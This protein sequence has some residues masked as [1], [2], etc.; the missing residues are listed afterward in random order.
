MTWKLNV[1]G[2][3]D[4]KPIQ[5]KDCVLRSM[6]KNIL[7]P[8]VKS[9]PTNVKFCIHRL[10]PST[11]HFRILVTMNN[12]YFSCLAKTGRYQHGW[13][14]SYT[15]HSIFVMSKGISRVFRRNNIIF[16]MLPMV[17]DC[18][19]L[20]ERPVMHVGIA[21]WSFCLK[22]VTAKTFP[23]FPAHAQPAILHTW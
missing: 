18:I 4:Q 3:H 8:G 6:T 11:Q 17:F 16:T 19:L 13:E 22:S 7:S 12:L 14:S 2:I 21:N 9:M 15:S 23:A 1:D 5:N 20:V 10:D